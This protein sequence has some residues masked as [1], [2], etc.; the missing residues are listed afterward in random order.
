M[1]RSKGFGDLVVV[2]RSAHVSAL[3]VDNL[4]GDTTGSSRR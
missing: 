2:T 4:E 1:K 3:A